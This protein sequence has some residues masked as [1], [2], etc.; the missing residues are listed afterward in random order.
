[1]SRRSHRHNRATDDDLY[2]NWAAQDPPSGSHSNYVAG[3]SYAQHGSYDR[4]YGGSSYG[5]QSSYSHSGDPNYG[6]R[7]QY[8]YQEQSGGYD[9]QGSQGYSSGGDDIRSTNL[10]ITGT[11]RKTAYSTRNEDDAARKAESSGL[12]TLGRLGVD[13]TGANDRNISDNE[14]A[15]RA[16]DSFRAGRSFVPGNSFGSQS[17]AREEE[18]RI[19]RQQQE[20]EERNRARES[21]RCNLAERS[22]Y[23]LEGGSD[24]GD[25]DE[26]PGQEVRAAYLELSRRVPRDF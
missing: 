9:S 1:M 3:N 11:E 22:R 19:A 18:A 4:G 17:R 14:L 13:Y 5:G 2:G 25:E 21:S 8:Q 15:S 7:Q 12:M 26:H 10:V 23:Q 20:M 16:G 6:H 24:M